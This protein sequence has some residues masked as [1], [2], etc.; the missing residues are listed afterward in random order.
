MEYDGIKLEWIENSAV[1]ID[2]DQVIYIDPFRIKVSQP[3]ADI[4]LITHEHYDHCSI[5]DLHKIVQPSTVIITVAGCQSKLSS[6]V[7]GIRDVIVLSPGQEAMIG[8]LRIRAVPAYNIGKPFHPKE[9]EWVGFVLDFD[10]TLIYHAGDTDLIPEMRNLRVDIAMLPVGGT[11]VMDA[12]QAAEAANLIRPKI[13]IPIHFGSVVGSV[14]DAGIFAR[15]CGCKV[16][17]MDRA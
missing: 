8:E 11:Y 14:A 7:S 17:V 15:E 13:A 5:E 2:C 16:V 1:R 10:G 9:N 6:I 12:H 3:K 4:V